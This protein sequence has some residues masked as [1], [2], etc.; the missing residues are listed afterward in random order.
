MR[1]GYRVRRRDVESVRRRGGRGARGRAIG[2]GP[3]DRADCPRFKG[4]ALTLM[5]EFHAEHVEWNRALGDRFTVG[6]EREVCLPV[7][8]T[9]TL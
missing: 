4:A 6:R 3:A 9:L 5:A 7:Q 8:L 2:L 1:A